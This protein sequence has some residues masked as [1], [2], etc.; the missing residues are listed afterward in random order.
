MEN[1]KK[2]S[3]VIP[4]FNEE[5]TIAALLNRV[6][7]VA[8]G[9]IQKEL[10]VVNDGSTDNTLQEIRNVR[11]RGIKFKLIN[12]KKNKGKSWALRTGFKYVTGDVVV[13]QDGDMEYEPNDF[14]KMLAKMAE[15]DVKVVFGSRILG[16]RRVN[17]SGLSFYLGGWVLTKMV[18]V[19]YGS[20]ITDEPTCYKMFETKLLKSIKL[21]SK[22]FE[23][24]PEVTAKVLKRG[25]SIYEVPI[26]YDPRHI[27]EG[28][29]I[30]V[31]DFW[32]AVLVLIKNRM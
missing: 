13:I 22:R 16:K 3:I 21:T 25:E 27:K 32:E 11:K 10:V 29:K 12:H 6:D 9:K 8:L 1:I 19:L 7:S 17:Y 5:K 31:N 4:V 26:A 30:R 24:C 18:N 28:K 2:L 15:R 20:S 14:N 23:F